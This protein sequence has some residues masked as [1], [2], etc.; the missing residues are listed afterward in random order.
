MKNLFAA[1]NHQECELRF[2][3][4]DGTLMWAHIGATGVVEDGSPVCRI[5]ISDISRRKTA[6][7]A[8]NVIKN[9]YETFFN[10][11]DDFLFVL[12]E[13]GKILHVN[14][15]VIKRLGYKKEELLGESVL[16]VHPPERREEAGR[17]IGEMLAGTAEFCPVPIATKA[18]WQIPVETRVTKGIWNNRPAIFGCRTTIHV[19][20]GGEKN[21]EK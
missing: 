7:L 3:K 2:I 19:V 5:I 12:D 18:G 16:M 17:I 11:I 6:E 21:S 9:N 13:Q 10:R 1:M 4:S 20:Q 8:V 15:I 14:D